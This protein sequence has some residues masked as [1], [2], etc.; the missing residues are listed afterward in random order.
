METQNQRGITN[1][2]YMIVKLQ[3]YIKCIEIIN[4]N[5]NIIV[6]DCILA[7]VLFIFMQLLN[8]DNQNQKQFVFRSKS[9]YNATLTVKEKQIPTLTMQN[10]KMSL[11]R[12]ILIGMTFHQLHFLCN[13]SIITHF[14]RLTRFACLHM[15]EIR[16]FRLF[17]NFISLYIPFLESSYS[18]TT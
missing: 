7:L 10:S 2:I 8:I 4:K 5:I 18:T 3:N 17:L 1:D 11:K 12:L 14:L 16:L 9:I 6:G 15:I 13:I